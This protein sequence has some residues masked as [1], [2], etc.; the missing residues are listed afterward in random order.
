MN[1]FKRRRV[2]DSR[3]HEIHNLWC[4]G[5]SLRQIAAGKGCALSA[6]AVRVSRHRDRFQLQNDESCREEHPSDAVPVP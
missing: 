2:V 4:S 6:I 3:D 1:S 5:M